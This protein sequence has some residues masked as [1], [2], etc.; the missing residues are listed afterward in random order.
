MIAGAVT[1]G[2]PWLDLACGT[3]AVAKRAATGGAHVTGI[4]LA[5][6]LIDTARRRA[7]ALGLEID[8]RVASALQSAG[9]HRRAPT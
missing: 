7:A 3:G 9:G 1:V 4:D 6:A 2:I 8:Y 5:P